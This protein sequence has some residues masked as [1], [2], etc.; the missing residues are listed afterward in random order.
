VWTTLFT[1][2]KRGSSLLRTAAITAAGTCFFLVGGL[3]SIIPS[4]DQ[5]VTSLYRSV[6]QQEDPEVNWLDPY[7]FDY[8]RLGNDFSHVTRD[9]VKQTV[10]L[11]FTTVTVTTTVTEKDSHGKTHTVTKTETKKVPRS[12]LDVMTQAGYSYEDYQMALALEN[13]LET[14][15]M[16][17]GNVTVKELQFVPVD[18]QKLYDYVHARGSLFTLQDMQDL[19][20]AAQRYNVSP[21]LLLAI[22]GQE[23]S[24]DP[25]WIDHAEQRHNNPWDV[26]HSYTD[27]NTSFADTANIAANTLAH[28]LSTPPPPGEDAIQ[29]C[30]DPRNPWGIYAEDPHWAYGV[31]DIYNSIMRYLGLPLS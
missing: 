13:L 5:N 9:H 10:D 31:E 3:L 27:Y 19:V 23:C 30:N 26:F 1:L 21:V 29:W 24:F 15:D 12:L 17:L 22:T 25:Y 2:S 28:K 8:F 11:F 18:P 20:A 16:P 4:G 7:I 6:T 14:E